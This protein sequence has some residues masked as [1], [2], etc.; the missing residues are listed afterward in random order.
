MG[1]FRLSLKKKADAFEKR[2]YSVLNS[3]CLTKLADEKAETLR[4]RLLDPKK[5]Y[6]RLFTF[7]KHCDVQPTN[8]QAALYDDS[9]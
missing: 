9:S 4:K 5:E 6:H 7:L 2:L 8:N 1:S 3:I